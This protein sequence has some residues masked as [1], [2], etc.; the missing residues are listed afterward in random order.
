MM[1]MLKSLQNHHSQMAVSNEI[2]L[3]TASEKIHTEAQVVTTQIA[4]A[5]ISFSALQNDLV[6][7]ADDALT[8]AR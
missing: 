1:A 2:A 8:T 6:G 3:Q 5:V 7:A 4:A